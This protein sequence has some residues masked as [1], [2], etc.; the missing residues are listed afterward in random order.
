MRGMNPNATDNNTYCACELC[1][2]LAGSQSR[3]SS[4]Y[5]GK[6]KN[7]IVG[8][9]KNFVLMPSIGQLGDA[10]FMIVSRTH[11]TAVANLSPDL[12]RELM[13]LLSHTRSWLTAKLGSHHVAFENGDP[14]GIGRMNC[15][16]SHLHVHLVASRH[17]LPSLARSVQQLGSQSV[18][19]LDAI[20]DIADPYS[21]VEIDSSGIQLIRRQQFN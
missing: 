19:S 21:F 17:N 8:G 1:A 4:L 11:E 14:K 10:H 7:R 16:I 3:F 15:S 13:F 6:L 2:E 20:T 9:S 18:S 12:R 5:S